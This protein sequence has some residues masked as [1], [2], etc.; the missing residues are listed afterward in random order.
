MRVKKLVSDTQRVMKHIE[1]SGGWAD[2]PAD[3][4]HG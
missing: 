2:D 4:F 1:T 3:F